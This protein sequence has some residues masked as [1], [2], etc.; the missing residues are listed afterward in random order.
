MRPAL[1]GG[2]TTALPSFDVNAAPS[3]SQIS[4]VVLVL[5]DRKGMIHYQTPAQEDENWDKLMKE[6]AIHQHIEEL[7]GSNSARVHREG[8]RVAMTKHDSES[9]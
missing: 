2:P 6:D 7:L 1:P 9:H 5:I 3:V 8:A 4:P